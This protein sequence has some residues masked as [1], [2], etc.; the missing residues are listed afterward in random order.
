MALGYHHLWAILGPSGTLQNL[1]IY[2][3]GHEG[4]S[5]LLPGFAIKW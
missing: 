1:E 5:V 2:V 4:V 3:S